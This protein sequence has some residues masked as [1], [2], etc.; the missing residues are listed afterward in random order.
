MSTGVKRSQERWFQC[1][2]IFS[3]SMN[4]ALMFLYSSRYENEMQQESIEDFTEEAIEFAVKKIETETRWDDKIK[5]D[6][7]DKLSSIKIIAGYP[8]G[9]LEPQKIEEMFS[10]LLLSDEQTF[11]SMTLEIQFNQDKVSLE[12]LQSERRKLNDET[13]DDTHEF[14]YSKSDK[15]LCKLK[16][17][18]NNSE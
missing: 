4:P 15:V 18:F 2:Q 8:K 3:D 14:K 13:M 1:V 12:P 16:F 6:L 7:I 9:I 11:V 5:K 17:Y 10:N